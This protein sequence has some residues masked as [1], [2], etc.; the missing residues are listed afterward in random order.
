MLW[1]H[2]C[3]A[4]D[5]LS[6]SLSLSLNSSLDV[7]ILSLY[8]V[9]GLFAGG[10]DERKNNIALIVL[11]SLIKTIR[12]FVSFSFTVCLRLLFL[13]SVCLFD[14]RSQCLFLFLSFSASFFLSVQ[15]VCSPACL[16]I[17]LSVCFCVCLS[18]SVSFCCL[19]TVCLP[20]SLSVCFVSVCLSLLSVMSAFSLCL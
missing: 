10:L 8:I 6:L 16:P 15:L 20:I 17:C 9:F 18:V 4:F 11:S 7:L 13:T 3:S 19:P 14:C 1:V 12:S 5:S 2:V